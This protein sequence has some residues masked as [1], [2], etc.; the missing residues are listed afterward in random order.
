[1][2]SHQFGFVPSMRN[3]REV[4]HMTIM[5]VCR[6]HGDLIAEQVKQDKK[7][8]RCK[9]CHNEKARERYHRQLTSDQIDEKLNRKICKLHGKLTRENTII[10][11]A[12]IVCR[13]CDLIHQ[14][15]TYDKHKNKYAETFRNT[16]RDIVNERLKQTRLENLEEFRQ[17]ERD[18]YHFNKENESLRRVARRRKIPY[19]ELLEMFEK[20]Q[21]KCATCG[22]EET[23]KSS[24]SNE[25]TNLCLD[26]H[27]LHDYN[28]E[29]LCHACNQVI[30]HSRE[31]IE[32]L[33]A[34]IKYIK[35]HHS[36]FL[37]NNL[38]SNT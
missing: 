27:H 4:L 5:K 17:Y 8:I 35:Y 9:A 28:R 19:K 12:I 37:K 20:Q 18:K 38:P 10:H 31:N 23:R 15:K 33:E 29:L 30:G 7:G 21:N 2:E 26:H 3:T 16:R 34:I 6:I 1:L 32:T 24:K 25:V 11:G 22:K 14:K 36:N 13:E